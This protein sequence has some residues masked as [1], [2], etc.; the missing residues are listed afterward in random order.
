[1][2]DRRDLVPTRSSTPTSPCCSRR[3]A[4]LT[5]DASLLDRYDVAAFDH[6]R[7]PGHAVAGRRRRDPRRWRS[8]CSAGVDPAESLA[9]PPVADELLHRI[10]EFCAGEPVDP[11]YVAARARRRPTSTARDRRRFAWD[12]PARRRRRSTRFRVAIIGAG[13]GGSAPPSGSSR[14]GS[15]TRSSTRTPASAARGS[16][17]PTPTSGS[18]CPTTSTRTRSR[19]TPTGP[20]TTRAATSSPAYIERCANGAT[21][22]PPHVRFGTEVLAADVRRRR[23]RAGRCR[24][25]ARRR[26]RRSRSRRTPL[27]SAVGMLNRPSV[28]DLDGLDTFAGPVVPLLALGPRPSTSRGK[29]VAV[30]GTGASAMQFVPAIAPDVDA[31]RRSSSGRATGSRPTPRTTGR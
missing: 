26:A 29:R 11:E 6:G 9:R 15:R 31:P 19:P 10:M 30:V 2:L 1:M 24:C 13:L 21:A 3:V 20:T 4:H 23:A 14:P 18:T 28:P 5:G 16:R 25:A 17:T 8:T 27:I 22:S 7:G 12:A